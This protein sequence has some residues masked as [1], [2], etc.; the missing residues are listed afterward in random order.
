MTLK[1]SV[2]HVLAAAAQ[3]GAPGIVA[4]IHDDGGQWFGSAGAADTT[5]GRQRRP[6]DRF[7]IGS[8]TK[9]FTATVVLQLAAEG[10]VSLDD[11]V[12]HWLPGLVHGNGN[13]GSKITV[14]QLLNQTSGVFGYGNDP[15]FFATGVGTAWFEHRYDSYTPEQLVKVALAHPPHAAPGETFSY[16]NTNYILA[17]MIIE[18]VTGHTYSQELTQRVISPLG[19][20][21]TSL[22]DDDPTIQ[23][24]HA[25]H[26]STLFSQDPE[27]T[28]HDA[29]EMDQSFAWSAGGIISTTTDLHRFFSA[30]LG[31][32]LLP[33]AQQEELFTTVSTDGS[34]WIPNTRY[35]LGIF[36]Q[37]LP[38][39]VDLWGNGGAHYGSWTY[40]M[41]S[42]NGAHLL[43]SNLN[44]DWSGLGPFNELLAAEFCPT[45]SAPG[46]AG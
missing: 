31:G 3:A 16:S 12:E 33:A 32:R 29:T 24:T 37:Q 46:T 17:A 4:E 11:T 38:C 18:K 30:L 42:Q 15:E 27:P 25:V 45:G 1:L 13:D 5:T 34:N 36:T 21:D 19:L 2:Q 23:G 10:K 43:V 14:R 9:A 26:Y 20:T 28:I 8:A 7:R 22:P 41:G 6:E 35:G 44:G 40:A 39:G